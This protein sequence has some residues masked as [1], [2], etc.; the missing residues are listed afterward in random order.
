MKSYADPWN[1]PTEPPRNGYAVQ[2]RVNPP[3]GHRARHIPQPC[4]QRRYRFAALRGQH[5]DRSGLPAVDRVPRQH[6]A[7]VVDIDY[8]Q[9]V[10]DP[11]RVR[12]VEAPRLAETAAGTDGIAHDL[13]GAVGHRFLR[14][15]RG[16]ARMVSSARRGE[17]LVR[18]TVRSS[19]SVPVSERKRASTAGGTRSNNR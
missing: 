11:H 9:Q 7:E 16:A 1:M 19:A 4:G 13:G 15:R 10:A 12:T 3:P 8:Q 6:P 2:P 14:R 17:S 5:R 18:M